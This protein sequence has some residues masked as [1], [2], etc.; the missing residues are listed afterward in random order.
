M[1]FSTNLA[2]FIRPTNPNTSAAFAPQQKL[3]N[4][5]GAGHDLLAQFL[6]L[7]LGWQA[8]FIRPANPNT[9]AAF[10]PEQK[11]LTDLGWLAE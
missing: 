2:E 9:S 4:D 5:L 8:E 3:L 6:F 7:Y 11:L 10:V 1:E